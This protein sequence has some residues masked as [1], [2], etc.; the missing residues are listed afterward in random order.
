MSGEALLLLLLGAKGKT[1]S[2]P[3]AR[4]GMMRLGIRNV[5]IYTYIGSA[6]QFIYPLGVVIS[7]LRTLTLFLVHATH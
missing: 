3:G 1:D 5:S 7:N 6:V 4:R 2:A